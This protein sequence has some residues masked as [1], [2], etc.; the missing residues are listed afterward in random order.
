ME[1]FERY[2]NLKTAELEDKEV[3]AGR[4]RLYDH[5]TTLTTTARA[6]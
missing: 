2:S 3:S 5:T 6:T 4:I 1:D